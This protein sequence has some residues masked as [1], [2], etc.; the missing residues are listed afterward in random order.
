MPRVK[1]RIVLEYATP[2]AVNARLA[3]IF[4]HWSSNMERDAYPELGPANGDMEVGNDDGIFSVGGGTLTDAQRQ[5][6]VRCGIVIRDGT[7]AFANVRLARFSFAGT[8]ATSAQPFTVDGQTYTLVGVGYGQDAEGKS[9]LTLTFN[10]DIT[11]PDRLD[12]R[13]NINVDNNSPPVEVTPRPTIKDATR[14]VTQ[15]GTNYI[16]VVDTAPTVLGQA[17]VSLNDPARPEVLPEYMWRGWAIQDWAS[18]TMGP[19]GRA[20]F[21]LTDTLGRAPNEQYSAAYPTAPG[22]TFSTMLT[23]LIASDASL[24]LSPDATVPTIDCGIIDEE[25]Q[26]R[27][28]FLRRLMRMNDGYSWV[29][30]E[31]RIGVASH[32]V[33]DAAEAVSYSDQTHSIR[34]VSLSTPVPG[35]RVN[36]IVAIGTTLTGTIRTAD[37]TIPAQTV[38]TF[39]TPEGDML[40]YGFQGVW[41]WPRNWVVTNVVYNFGTPVPLS[42]IHI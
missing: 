12:V 34:D 16:W 42:L 25:P 1:P 29:D 33:L 11:L 28:A 38:G 27:L 2:M 37:I 41:Y 5:A 21:T 9:A 7:P 22:T 32:A 3:S 19:R 31:G 15:G 35:S 17:T 24:A 8:S 14:T 20:A 26:N 4:V 30:H 23:D 10:G 18:A 6:P 13:Q 39:T 36:A 40:P